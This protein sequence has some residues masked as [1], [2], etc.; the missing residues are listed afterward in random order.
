MPKK[1]ARQLDREIEETL[2]AYD[3]SLAAQARRLASRWRVGQLEQPKVYASSVCLATKPNGE[4][5]V[6]FVGDAIL[7]NLPYEVIP[8]PSPDLFEEARRNAARR[9]L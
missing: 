3:A 1:T 7:W 9:T 2:G 4:T 8:N 5:L 6:M